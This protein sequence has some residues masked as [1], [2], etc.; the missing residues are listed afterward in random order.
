MK[1]LKYQTIILV[2]DILS[3]IRSYTLFK[4]FSLLFVIN[5]SGYKYRW[6]NSL[7]KYFFSNKMRKLDVSKRQKAEF[8]L[9]II[10][11]F[12]YWHEKIISCAI[13]CNIFHFWELGWIVNTWYLVKMYLCTTLELEYI[14][15]SI[16]CVGE[17]FT[18]SVFALFNNIFLNQFFKSIFYNTAMWCKRSTFT[19][20]KYNY[21]YYH[22]II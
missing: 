11:W 14:S 6:V 22:N 17:V 21:Y 16:V 9:A 1:P 7:I 4:G 12:V 8:L 13:N 15:N 19:T 2:T 20:L 10:I 3:T 5:W 18:L